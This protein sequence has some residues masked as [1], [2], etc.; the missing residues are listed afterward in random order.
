MN[1]GSQVNENLCEICKLF[2]ETQS[3]LLQCPEIVP[4][5]NLISQGSQ[6]DEN[7]VYGNVESQLKIVKI[8][9]KILEKRKE[10]LKI[11]EEDQKD[12]AICL[13]S[14][15]ASANVSTIGTNAAVTVL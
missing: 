11:R 6:I 1:F 9:C 10:I 3:H 14:R 12:D 13:K 2:P 5:L 7:F 15:L 4:K 8:Y